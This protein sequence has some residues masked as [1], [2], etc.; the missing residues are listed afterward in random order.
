MQL[1]RQPVPLPD[2]GEDLR[3]EDQGGHPR[4]PDR[5]ELH[6]RKRSSRYYCN[7]V[8][9]G[10]GNY[11]VEAASEFLF[12]KSIK[13][14]TLA[15][16]ALVAGLP[17]NPGRLSP[18]EHPERAPAAPQPRPRSACSRRSTSRTRRPSAAQA[19][20]LHLSLN[21]RSAVDRALLPRGGAQ[22]PGAG[23][24]QP[25]HLPG[26]P[27]R[28][29]DPRSRRLQ[30]RGQRA[31][32]ATGCACIDRRSRGFV[33]PHGEPSSRTASSRTASTSRTG[34]A[35]PRR[36]TSCAAW[37]SP[38]ARDRRRR[39]IGEYEARIGPRR[40]RLDQAQQRGRGAQAGRDGARSASSPSPE[41]P[42]EETSEG[43]ARAGAEGARARSSPWSRR[44]ARCGPW[45][46]ATT[47]SAAS[48]TAPR[49]PVR[50][51]GS[52]FKP[53]VYAAAIEKAGYTPATIIVD[54]PISFPTE[55]HG[56]DA[57]QLRLQVPRARSPAPRASRTAG[58]CPPS[59]RS[60]AV[61]IKTGIE[62]AHKLGLTGEL[63]PYLPLA[64]GRGR[65]H[66]SWR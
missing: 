21:A 56:L 44:R 61:G 32:C 42:A 10:H 51:V 46:A 4:L 5:E 66:A 18:V 8:Y 37:C 62:Y 40:D 50:Q 55:Q 26:R 19:E 41:R 63:P 36:T 3:A 1:V 17:Q 24:R 23:V 12:S 64:L 60:Q 20:P 15:E 43:D 35:D 59:R 9:F 45:W 7:Q 6:R 34:T 22:V 48:S 33:P 47:S 29:H 57:A 54:A 2:P 58:T 52:A 27:A 31:P 38:R 25:A 49:R 28:L 53:I 16:A 30:M 65:G 11:G 39:S 13:D 14:L